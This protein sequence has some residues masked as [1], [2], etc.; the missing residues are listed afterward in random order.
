MSICLIVFF[1]R[2]YNQNKEKVMKMLIDMV[3]NVDL[4]APQARTH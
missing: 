2:E 4:K 1:S 3:I